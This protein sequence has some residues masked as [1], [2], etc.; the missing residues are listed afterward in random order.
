M[1]MEK[2][3]ELS[4]SENYKQQIY[5][6]LINSKQKFKE[7]Y[8]RMYGSSDDSL[9]EEAIGSDDKIETENDLPYEEAP[10]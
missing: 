10:I 2:N 8:N 1:S 3:S 7:L 9:I 6:E 4:L 5:S